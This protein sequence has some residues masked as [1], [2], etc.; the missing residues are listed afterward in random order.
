MLALSS[1][2]VRRDAAAAEDVYRAGLAADPTAPQT[3]GGYAR[4]LA[5]ERG[6][7]ARAEQLYLQA[8]DNAE[9]GFA[10]GSSSSS[11]SS[12]GAGGGNSG[13][14]SRSNAAHTL[15]NLAQLLKKV[16][17]FDECEAALRRALRLDPGHPQAL[18]N[19]ANFLWRSRGDAAA[20]KQVGRWDF[21]GVTC[22]ICV[23]LHAFMG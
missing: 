9:A 1:F 22:C 11:S 4:F 5:T 12:N 6:D 7:Y 16:E 18:N 17:R 20:A 15:V 3:L 21:M 13:S 2:K 14:W 23:V 19:L 10:S 8:I